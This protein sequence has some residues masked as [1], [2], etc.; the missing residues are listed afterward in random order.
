MSPTWWS[1]TSRAALFL[2]IRSNLYAVTRRTTKVRQSGE[3]KLS[4]IVNQPCKAA[5]S[6][7]IKR[8]CNIFTAVGA[9]DEGT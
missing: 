4:G 3:Q 7:V 2:S 5:R 8:D 1:T 6:K 9:G